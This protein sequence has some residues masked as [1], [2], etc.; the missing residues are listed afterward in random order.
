MSWKANAPDS[1][2][3]P[4]EGGVRYHIA[5]DGEVIGAYTEAEF[6]SKVRRL[7]IRSTDYFFVEGMKEWQP[8]YEYQPSVALAPTPTPESV[9]AR[10]NRPGVSE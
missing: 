5:R 10:E 8:V 3:P 1:V 6:A 2:D 7:E 9:R 4:T